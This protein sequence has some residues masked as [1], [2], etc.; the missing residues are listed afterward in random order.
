MPPHSQAG[1]TARPSER[2]GQ[3]QR[4]WAAGSGTAG[5]H[6]RRLQRPWPVAGRLRW[7][8]CSECGGGGRGGCSCGGFCGPRGERRE[9]ASSAVYSRRKRCRARA[10]RWR[11]LA[12]ARALPPTCRLPRPNHQLPFFSFFNARSFFHHSPLRRETR[13]SSQM[14]DLTSKRTAW[15]LKIFNYENDIEVKE[16]RQPCRC[17]GRGLLWEGGGF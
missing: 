17:K 13:Q 2:S 3:R 1:G 9:E 11:A 16:Q 10:S 8:G 14:S 5:Q 7:R 4:Q 15:R 12:L 6:Q